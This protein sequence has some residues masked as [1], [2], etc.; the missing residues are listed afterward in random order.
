MSLI[1][2][3]MFDPAKLQMNCAS[4]SGSTKR[5]AALSGRP[6]VKAPAAAAELS[7]TRAR[8]SGLDDEPAVDALEGHLHLVARSLHGSRQPRPT[9]RRT[10]T[11]AV[12]PPPALS[13]SGCMT[14]RSGRGEH[15]APVNASRRPLLGQVETPVVAAH[16]LPAVLR[17]LV[18]AQVDEREAELAADRV[19]GR[20]VDRRIRIEE[21]VLPLR[22][23]SLDHL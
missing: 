15:V 23:R 8:M 12:R 20:V 7:A 11:V 5:R 16:D 17:I 1:I 4:A 13:G 21:P 3:F 18:L 9:R 19:R 2:T 6:D 14:R 22:L 10:S